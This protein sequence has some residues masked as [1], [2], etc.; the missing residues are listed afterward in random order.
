[1]NWPGK[2][3]AE[4]MEATWPPFATRDLGPFRLRDGAGGGKRVSAAT[5]HGSW[6]E[7][8]LIAAEAAIA[9]PLF[10]IYEGD[11]ALDAA[12]EA[13][14]YEVIDPVVIYAAPVADLQMD[15]PPLAAFP[16]W[17]PLETAREIW[18]QGGIGPAR[19]R[20]ME[21]VTGA[22][23]AILARH[24]DRPAGACFVALS[25]HHAMIHAIEIAPHMRRQGAGASLL[26]A[27]ANWAADAGGHSLSLAVTEQ[28]TAARALY[29]RAG[30]TI[31]GK[32]HYRIRK[33]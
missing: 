29:D 25:G 18:E 5:V 30:M 23:T 27:A 16:H 11:A 14:G 31:V 20:V 17:P 4:V 15:L 1:M 26:A 7:A 3:I 28:N 6:D 32:Y 12:L 2:L 24:S 33:A 22:K 21:R 10:T 9:E 13:R 8:A 19:I